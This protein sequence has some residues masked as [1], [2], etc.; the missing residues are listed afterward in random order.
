M[1]LLV[2][3]ALVT[4]F[5]IVVGMN[6]FQEDADAAERDQILLLVANLATRAQAWY[7]TPALLGGGG[8]SFADFSFDKIHFRPE[9][10]LGTVNLSYCVPGSVRI[11][12]RL[13]NDRNWSIVVDV[14]PD[15]FEVTH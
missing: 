5:T 1:M 2:L 10:S 6:R 15:S 13:Y 8:K 9:S 3:A 12:G 7:H 14:Y 4:A 11:V